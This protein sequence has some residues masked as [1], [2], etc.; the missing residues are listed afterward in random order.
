MGLLIERE[1]FDEADRARFAARLHD[2]L[3]ALAA[4]LDRPGFGAGPSSLGAELELFLIDAAGR[5]LP[6]NRAVLAAT[7]DP[8]VTVEVDRF[9][10]EI[11]TRPAPL[12]GRP[13]SALGGEL[14]SALAEV[15]RAAGTHGGRV[16]TIGILPTLRAADLEAGALTDLPRFRALSAGI[17]RLR[18]A[19]FTI[20][21]DGEDPLTFACDDVTLEGANTSLQVHLRT[22]P[23]DFARTYNAAQIATAPVLAA[24]G[25]SPLFLGHRLWE[26]TRV[27][28]FRQATDDRGDP[29][30]EWRPARVSFGH[31]W[32]R[33]GALELF[34]ESVLQHP[35]LLP[36]VGPEDPVACVRA[37][38]VPELAELRLHQGT[39]WRWNRAVYDPGSGGHLRIE[40][41]ALPAG[42]SIPDMVANAAFLVGL[43]LALAPDAERLTA[44]LT[45]GQARRSFYA[46]A[47]AGLDAEILWPADDAPSP[48]PVR[49]GDLVP[50]LLPQARAGLLTA[51]VDAAEIDP[52][53][54][55]IAAR[56]ARGT[57]G[58]RWQ[59]QTLADLERTRPRDAALAAMLERY[60]A[61]AASGA[62]VHGWPVGT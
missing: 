49:A 32:V 24:A 27:A 59:L 33:H 62:P 5:G 61:A 56:V 58:A 42:P 10:L 57:T 1:E 14:A 9:N 38:G 41:R 30:A 48:R 29:S 40:L 8:R 47:R 21:I 50:R 3:T 13:F 7:L 20:A 37:G 52:L 35:P 53:L 28:L 34:A 51:G 11:N 16:T 43:T 44:A 39:V 45:F 18:R 19:P 12:R 26:E 60:V 22:P 31:G 36:V 54:A 55:L 2:G 23:A 25:N 46:A 15:G 17:R 6:L 4:L